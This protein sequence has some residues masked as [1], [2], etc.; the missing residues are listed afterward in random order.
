MCAARCWRSF[1]QSV[2]ASTLFSAGGA[3]LALANHRQQ[4]CPPSLPPA[5]QTIKL[6]PQQTDASPLSK[7]GIEKMIPA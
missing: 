4:P 2:V 3:A 1:Y 5:G 6:F 7:G